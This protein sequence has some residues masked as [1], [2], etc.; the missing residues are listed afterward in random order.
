MKLT[1]IKRVLLGGGVLA[2]LLSV[3]GVTVG[4][5]DDFRWLCIGNALW[6]IS[7]CIP[8]RQQ[9]LAMELASQ[10]IREAREWERSTR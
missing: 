10:K 5:V 1:V 6:I 2:L 9:R 4:S 3:L 7:A 8:N